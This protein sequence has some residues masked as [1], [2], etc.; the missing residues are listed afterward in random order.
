LTEAH[1]LEFRIDFAQIVAVEFGVG[2]HPTGE[3]PAA[4]RPVA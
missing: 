1:T 2:G 4:E 3:E